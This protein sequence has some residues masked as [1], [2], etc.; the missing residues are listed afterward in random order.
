MKF[1]TKRAWALWIVIAVSA[2]S[3]SLPV[4]ADSDLAMPRIQVSGEGRVDIAPDMAVL[5]LT[6]TREAQTA[7]AALDANSSAMKDVLA[8]MASQGINIKDLQTSSFSI[9]PKYSY[10]KSTASGERNPPKIAGYSVRNSL[11]VRIRDINKVGSI[12]DKSISL[13]VNEGGNI[14]FTNSDPTKAIAQARALAVKDAITKADT[15]AKAAGVSTGDILGISERS[16]SQHPV[17]IARTTMMMAESSGSVPLAGG[18]NTYIVSVNVSL[19][20]KQ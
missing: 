18:E 4:R 8:A 13:G 19:A 5:S 7:R 15:L 9:Q 11:T 20:I 17:P 6:V 3:A 12:L 10:A 14:S 2:A 1:L 16:D